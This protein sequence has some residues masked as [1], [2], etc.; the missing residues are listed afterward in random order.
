MS[1]FV[2]MYNMKKIILDALAKNTMCCFAF[3]ICFRIFVV[4]FEFY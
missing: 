2:I 1:G 4:G 3:L